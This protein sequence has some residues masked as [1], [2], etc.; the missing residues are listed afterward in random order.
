MPDQ[1]H[2]DSKHQ[3]QAAKSERQ[4]E[5]E[6]PYICL[7]GLA[8]PSRI[9]LEPA[10]WVSPCW[11]LFV[12]QHVAATVPVRVFAILHWVQRHA[13]QR[14]GQSLLAILIRMIEIDPALDL[15]RRAIC[16][17]FVLAAFVNVL[18]S[19]VIC[20]VVS[21]SAYRVVS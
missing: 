21:N 16:E 8:E 15:S 12:D 18:V 17:R 11:H 3:V 14:R 6:A 9:D 19:L 1:V 13:I 5:G 2:E 4:H 10:I 20:R 7:P